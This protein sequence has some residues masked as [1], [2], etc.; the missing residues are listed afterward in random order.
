[1]DRREDGSL[2]GA[3]GGVSRYGVQLV[4]RYRGLEPAEAAVARRA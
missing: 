4:L 1:M 3:R 2:G